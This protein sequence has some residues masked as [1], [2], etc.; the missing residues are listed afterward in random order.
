EDKEGQEPTDPYLT[1]LSSLQVQATCLWR[2]T[3]T[4]CLEL[5]RIVAHSLATRLGVEV[6]VAQG[7]VNRL[8]KEGF[9]KPPT[10]PKKL[11]RV[12]D[13][14]KIKCEGLPKYMKKPEK[15]TSEDVVLEPTE[16]AEVQRE[17]E[18]IQVDEM[19]TLAEKTESL[20]LQNETMSNRLS[21]SKRRNK[22]EKVSEPKTDNKSTVASKPEGNK[23]GRGSRKR[24]FPKNNE[25]AEFELSSTQD[26]CE[27]EPKRR[28]KSSVPTNAI[29]V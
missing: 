22:T 26:V 15:K 24:A 7:L 2:R 28:K 25:D 1:S 14:E 13:K 12:V 19:E 29:R 17:P 23:K 18:P 11:G 16:T 9:L 4:A 20:N 6:T 21:R 27:E 8:N 10:K 3:L 5:D